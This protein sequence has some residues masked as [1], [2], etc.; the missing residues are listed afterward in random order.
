MKKWYSD[1]YRRHL[2][3]MHIEDWDEKFLSE[4]DPEEYFNNL[5]LAKIQ[6]AM[7]Y[8]QSHVGLCNFPTKV[9]EEHK[10]FVGNDKMKRLIKLCREN[11]IKVVGYYSLIHN[12]RAEIDHPDWKMVEADGKTPR[13]KGGRYGFVCPNNSEYRAFLVE[14]IKEMKENFDLDGM[15]YDMP[16]WP[17]NCRC[18]ACRDRWEKE[19]GGD[20]PSP[21]PHDPRFNVYAKKLQEWMAEFCE[22]VAD[23][24]HEIM[25]GVTIEFNNAGIV[26]F[27]WTA[28]STEKISDVADYAGGDLYGDLSSH[29]FACKYFYSITKNQPF[30]NMNSRCV[31]LQEHTATKDFEYLETEIA[32]TR[33]HHG[34][35]FI[36]DAIDPVGTMDKRVYEMLGKIFSEQE[37]SEKYN[38]G[39]YVADVA[40]FF[41]STARFKKDGQPFDNKDAAVAATR[42]LTERHVPTAVIANG[43]SGNLSKYKCVV[44]PMLADFDN[45]EIE[46]L[47][48]YVKNG[49]NLYFDGESDK[50]LIRLLG[51]ENEGFAGTSMTYIAPKKE[52]EKLLGDFNVKYPIPFKYKLPKISL[53]KDAEVLATV[54]LPYTVPEDNLHFAAI[55]SN[56]PGIST[57][58][59]AIVTRRVGK[60]SVTWCAGAL[61]T[62]ERK[63]FGDMFLALINRMTGGDYAV[64]ATASE[65]VETITFKTEKAFYISAVSLSA[66]PL[67]EY[68]VKISVKTGKT[69]V[70]IKKVPEETELSFSFVNGRTEFCDRVNLHSSYVIE[71]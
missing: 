61:E 16:F 38:E 49:G 45:P 64:S 29:S 12:N 6:C 62:D 1:N 60:G 14:Q 3:D 42:R 19:V 40:V 32:L 59:P 9:S 66:D 31:R 4:F 69:P 55:H 30:E 17:D 54:V 11:G 67:C 25:P 15:F 46:K 27:D 34:A 44:A 21:D 10:A 2:L 35:T 7:I 24:T 51:G 43:H 20:M 23:K 48:E 71:L 47:I 70:K 13:E 57:D 53:G 33:A 58:V 63:V 68:P 37:Y 8:L 5:K 36:I 50:R 65:N 56:P 52:F 39:E 18:K 26:A 22:F 41:D 28:G